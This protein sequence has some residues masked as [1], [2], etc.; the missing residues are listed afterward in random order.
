MARSV[1]HDVDTFIA[2]ARDLG[3]RFPEPWLRA[4]LET[5][6]Q[7]MSSA[8]YCRRRVRGW[9]G[10]TNVPAALR[11][12][13][14]EPRLWTVSPLLWR[15]W[16]IR[17]HGN[18]A[19]GE[20]EEARSRD[21]VHALQVLVGLLEL[22]APA[23]LS[24]DG[25]ALAFDMANASVPQGV[26][27]A[28]ALQPGRPARTRSGDLR[29]RGGYDALK[30]RH[31]R[32]ALK[33]QAAARRAVELA[34]ALLEAGALEATAGVAEQAREYVRRADGD[35][36][37]DAGE[38]LPDRNVIA[39]L[40]I[41]VEA[42]DPPADMV[43][44]LRRW[45]PVARSPRD[46]QQARSNTGRVALVPGERMTVVREVRLRKGLTQ[47]EL[48][49]RAEVAI[50]T[51]R[52]VERDGACAP[53]L[54]QRTVHRIARALGMETEELRTAEEKREFTR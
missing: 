33:K 20:W 22:A 45:A 30:A 26:R 39:L 52:K 32:D 40:L 47:Q 50:Q 25:L 2:R 51:L 23:P 17:P 18:L 54:H 29:T 6:R 21:P 4:L 38:V 13:R 14:E 7:W 1:A 48:A 5:P 35:D 15:T 19:H 36:L 9:W 27:L 31:V 10:V 12:W 42:F 16:S 41:D 28:P 11:S 49:T 44:M 24:R 3:L 34:E 43:K 8:Q 53:R 37:S 46:G